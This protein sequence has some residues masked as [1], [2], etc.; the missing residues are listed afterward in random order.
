MKIK[1]ITAVFIILSL[2]ILL[3]HLFFTR[4][5]VL[6]DAFITYRFS[7]N[8]A[9]GQGIVWNYQG[10]P[11]EGY[12]NFLL[13][14]ILVPFLQM[15]F[16]PLWVTRALS[17]LGLFLMSWTVVKIADYFSLEKNWQTLLFCLFITNALF[18]YHCMLGMETI[19]FSCLLMGEIYLFT[20][21]LA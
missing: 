18:A 14:L 9:K 19:I 6:D 5:R 20:R 21:S 15:G 4:H 8:I 2:F 10:K 3:F 17:L 12:T 7:K 13:V 1:K 11:T 16:S